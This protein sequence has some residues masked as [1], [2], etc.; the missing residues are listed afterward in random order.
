MRF[1]FH[2][3]WH[4][5]YMCDGHR[6]ARAFCSIWLGVLPAESSKIAPWV[7]ER[8]VNGKEA[9][10]FVVLADQADLSGAKN[11]SDKG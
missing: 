6:G 3:D 2:F 4:C 10:F 7:I 9:E 5:C 1:L 11:F 8:T